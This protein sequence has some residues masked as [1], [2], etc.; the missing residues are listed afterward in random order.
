[1]RALGAATDVLPI[2]EDQVIVGIAVHVVGIA[3][4]HHHRQIGR[5]V[6]QDRERA[7][8]GL[9]RD[10]RQRQLTDLLIRQRRDAL[11]V[12]ERP[13]QQP[14]RGA[15]PLT[16]ER[17]E[18]NTRHRRLHA[19]VVDQDAEGRRRDLAELESLDRR[20]FH[21]AIPVDADG[22]GRVVDGLRV[23]GVAQE[24]C[25]ARRRVR[26]PGLPM[27]GLALDDG[28]LGAA[29]PQRRRLARRRPV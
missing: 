17:R 11:R 22:A 4:A 1:M 19:L 23:G 12:L 26:L 2:G 6:E 29:L 3:G 18:P 28:R 25:L 10:R 5:A 13:H 14:R 21:V 15:F 7:D 27:F 16:Q 8:T 20:I 24:F 9:D